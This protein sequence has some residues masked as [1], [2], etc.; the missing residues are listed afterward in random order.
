[1]EDKP[2]R[3]RI[4]IKSVYESQLIVDMEEYKQN[5]CSPNAKHIGS[6]Y[7]NITVNFWIDK[8]YS[9][10]EQHGE[11]DGTK[12]NGIGLEDIEK[13]V[14]KALPHLIYYSLKHK[15]FQF[16]NHPPPRQRSLRVVLK[17]EFNSHTTLNIIVEY[18][19]VDTNTYE[20][21]VVTAMRKEAFS[22]SVGQHEL[23]FN[24]NRSVLNLKNGNN[25]QFQ[26][27][28]EV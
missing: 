1:M 23:I 28:F 11:D 7:E 25:L 16:V 3:K 24:D 14:K 15:G 8:H 21:T 22:I 4:P 18:H 20:V 12:R 17:E 26:D 6:H 10:R 19:F 27:N 2:K 13:L 9:N 5:C